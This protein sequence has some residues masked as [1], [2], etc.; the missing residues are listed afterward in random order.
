MST[1]SNESTILRW[2]APGRLIKEEKMI[3]EQHNRQYN[4]ELL[5]NKGLR[6]RKISAIAAIA[7]F[8]ALLF[9]ATAKAQELGSD[10]Q[11][12]F[13]ALRSDHKKGNELKLNCS[14]T[15]TLGGLLAKLN[16]DQAYT[17]T[18]SGACTENLD[19]T[20]FQHLSLLSQDGA[21]ISD[22]SGGTLP[23]INVQRSPIFEMEGFTING[24]DVGVVCGDNSTCFFA[25]NT[26]QNASN[27]GVSV[28]QLSKA[29]FIGDVIQN[30]GAGLL[31]QNSSTVEMDEVSLLNNGGGAAVGFGSTL[32]AGGSVVQGN[33]GFGL[34]A[35]GDSLLRLTE[36]T[37]SMNGGD[38]VLAQRG[39]VAY[40]LGGN[41]VSHNA[42]AGV[43]IKDL[44]LG[45][46]FDSDITGNLGGTDVLCEPQLPVT[47]GTATNI[48]GGST[49]CVETGQL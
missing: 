11:P 32:I 30:N 13:K 39:S 35:N 37:I 10:T 28:F 46:F 47:R 21:S 29:D 3:F 1:E 24:G 2:G 26:V 42:Q 40:L 48:N 36:N 34:R 49:N 22:A 5:T 41:I 43:R 16:P 25:N 6:M 19:I 44:S 14:G 12:E 7:M 8:T 15:K 9:S 38:G 45:V 31:V 23:V 17:I 33:T 4:S 27:E 18:V 20:S